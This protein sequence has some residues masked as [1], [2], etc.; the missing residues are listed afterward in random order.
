MSDIVKKLRAEP[1]FCA[2]SGASREQIEQAEKALSL[3]FA[4]EYREYLAAFGVA[5]VYGHELTGIC[6]SP[7]I[8]VVDVTISERM[9]NHT[10][11]TNWYVVEQT[12]IDGIVVWQSSTGEVCQTT[13]NAP[14]EKLCNSLCEY[15][16]I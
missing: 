16:E 12:H 3:R 10:V 5:S 2:M 7:R 8:N 15:L 6:A 1:N 4:D 11:P 9:S 14:P 13:P